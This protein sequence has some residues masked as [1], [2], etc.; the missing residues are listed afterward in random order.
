MMAA[1][2]FDPGQIADR[3]SRAL[4]A[5]GDRP[6][7]VGYDANAIQE[8]ITASGRPIS[9]RGASEVILD[10]DKEVRARELV[11]FAGGGRGVILARSADDA[12][13]RARA[14]VDRY[15]AVTRGGV[16]A[17]CAVPLERRGDEARSIRWLRHRLEIAKDEALPPGGELSATK[18]VE[19]AYCRTYRAVRERKRDDEVERL[20][21]QCDAMLDKGRDTGRQ[22]G[23][24]FGEMSRSIA[25]IAT[26][27]WIGVISAD[28]NNLGAM[29]ESLST[30]V[31]L[32]VVSEAVADAFRVAQEAALDPIDEQ[33][34]VPLVT[35]GDDVRA[36]LPPGDVLGYV[37]RLTTAVESLAADHAR[38]AEALISPKIAM[39]LHKLGIGIGAVIASVYYPARRLVAYA[40]EL[41]DSAK[42]G[43]RKHKWRSGF[44]F[45]VVT[46]EDTMTDRPVRALASG[47]VRPLP[48]CTP[49]WHAAL[50]NVR[51]LVQIPSA[52]L[53]ILSAAPVA[54]DGGS[55]GLEPDARS[56]EQPTGGRDRG[57][58]DRDLA[59]Q[60]EDWRVSDEELA[61]LL[62]YQVAR[63][64]EWQA[65]YDACDVD[66]RDPV[67]VFEHR[68][69]RDVLELARLLEF[70]GT[71]R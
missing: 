47:D 70:R 51:A 52:Q 56:Q 24:R 9:M 13:Q 48:P 68:P 26:D 6:W 41:E 42:A 60:S 8:L 54:R 14:F 32:A 65:W 20:C 67:K 64:K 33:K 50:R 34:R 25:D 49:Q 18:E 46:T 44:D 4:A 17:T 37:E 55:L 63:S 2:A 10:F 7:L 30:L 21:V 22:R 69:T 15:R 28:G 57:G 38:A 35:G 43:C 36:F 5:A 62:R 16:M 61:N 1:S 66:W 12:S 39:R 40:H 45:T 58:A 3:V 29:F 27:G 23:A 31:E 53:A 59:A 11:I 19:C 71:L